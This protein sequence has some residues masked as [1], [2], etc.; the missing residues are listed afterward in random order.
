MFSDKSQVACGNAAFLNDSFVVHNVAQRTQKTID[1]LV[2]SKY[3]NTIPHFKVG[4]HHNIFSNTFE[5]NP[6]GGICGLRLVWL[7]MNPYNSLVEVYC[8]NLN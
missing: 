8:S 5:I 6:G 7:I 3:R 2:L 4:Y 1:M